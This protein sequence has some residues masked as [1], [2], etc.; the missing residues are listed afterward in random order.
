MVVMVHK[1]DFESGTNRSGGNNVMNENVKTFQN[2]F[3]PDSKNTI[4][5]RIHTIWRPLEQKRPYWEAK[6]S[7]I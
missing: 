7:Y 6:I 3:K 5:G 4:L 1:F 2:I